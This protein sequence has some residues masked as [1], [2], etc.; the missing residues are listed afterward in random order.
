MH[1]RAG[2]ETYKIIVLAEPNTLFPDF[3]YLFFFQS[4]CSHVSTIVRKQESL[5]IFI[6]LII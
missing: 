4:L 5:Y 3:L 2:E 6:P 1:H